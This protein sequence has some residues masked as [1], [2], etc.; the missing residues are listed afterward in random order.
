MK[1]FRRSNI[2]ICFTIFL[3]TR[4]Y[5][6]LRLLYAQRKLVEATEFVECFLYII[7]KKIKL[8][9]FHSVDGNIANI[10]LP[11]KVAD[12]KQFGFLLYD[13]LI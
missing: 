11:L 9:V 4:V 5:D 1:Y 7:E 12:G 8:G 2:T 3:A 6:P 13:C 10:G